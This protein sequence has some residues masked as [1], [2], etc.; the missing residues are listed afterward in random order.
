[1]HI[2]DLIQQRKTTKAFDP[3]CQLT[4]DQIDAVCSLLRMSPS[5]T[6]AQPWHFFLASSEAAKAKVA[7]G[8]SG[9]FAYN[10][11]KIKNAALVVVMCA[12]T[13]MDDTYLQQ[14][15]DQESTD[16]RLA[17]EEARANQHKVRSGYVQKHE[18]SAAGLLQWSARQVYIAL[19]FLLLG[20]A[21]MGIDA[22]PIEGFD[23]AAMDKA[24][25][26]E[27]QGLASQVIVALGR[28]SDQDFNAGL[29]KSRLADSF[30]ITKL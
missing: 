14:V 5:S 23:A 22:C 11:P 18:Q 15:L 2:V 9:D 6:N 25:D 20:A 7:A 19:G 16:G 10:E 17:T 12:R 30:V 24:L 28:K 27:A 13:R 21:E 29:P 26:L 3:A 1:M 4:Q 8:T